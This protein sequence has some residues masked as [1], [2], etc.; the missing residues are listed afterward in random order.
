MEKRTVMGK[1]SFSS[2][3]SASNSKEP[4]GFSSETV[5]MFHS[6][7]SPET[8]YEASKL[9]TTVAYDDAEAGTRAV[10]AFS[11]DAPKAGRPPG[12]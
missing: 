5:P 1:K 10:M 9:D 8:S 3:V 7:A 11:L 12:A 4:L 6:T 2:F